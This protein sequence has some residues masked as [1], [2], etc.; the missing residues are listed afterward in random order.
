V[1]KVKEKGASMLGSV[2]QLMKIMSRLC[3]C[4]LSVSFR[5][6]HNPLNG[7]CEHFNGGFVPP[8][9]V[10][11]GKAVFTGGSGHKTAEDSAEIL[12]H[13]AGESLKKAKK[14]RMT[15][16]APMPITASFKSIL[17]TPYTPRRAASPIMGEREFV[18]LIHYLSKR[19]DRGVLV[20]C[21]FFYS[22]VG[23]SGK[24]PIGQRYN[25]KRTGL[26]EVNEV[27]GYDCGDRLIRTLESVMYHTISQWCHGRRIR[28]SKVLMARFI[29]T[30]TIYFSC[31]LITEKSLI[32]LFRKFL[33]RCRSSLHGVFL[34]RLEAALVENREKIDGP[35]L[36]RRVDLAGRAGGTI[37]CE[38]GELLLKRYTY[39]DEARG[40]EALEEDAYGSALRLKGLHFTL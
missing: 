21:E 28:R 6:L 13:E 24:C 30:F 9:S 8:L 18:T 37:V 2:R 10:T 12:F 31:G 7:K 23:E 35:E 19:G 5:W 3:C 22:P 38:S 36:V 11:F 16:A 39:A 27:L 15:V 17:T 4:P 20:Q 34:A 40:M 32:A 33:T 26:K 1:A 29:D 25:E 14:S